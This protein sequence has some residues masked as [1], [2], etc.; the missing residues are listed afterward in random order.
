MTPD[1]REAGRPVPTRP[2]RHVT[3]SDDGMMVK[4][5]VIEETLTAIGTRRLLV[6]PDGKRDAV[7]VAGWRIAEDTGGWETDR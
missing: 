3:F 5:E 2:K 7:W 1:G 6:L 4:G